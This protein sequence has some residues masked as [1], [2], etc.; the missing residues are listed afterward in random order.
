MQDDP[1][2]CAYSIADCTKRGP[3]GRSTIYKEIA[4]GRLKARKVGRRTIILVEDWQSYW[5]GLPPVTPA[6]SSASAT[7]ARWPRG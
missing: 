2:I 3:V 1:T 7:T 4:A 6:A 5:A